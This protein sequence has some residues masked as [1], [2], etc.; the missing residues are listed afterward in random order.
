MTPIDNKKFYAQSIQRFGISPQGVHWNSKYSQ[1]KRFEIITSCIKKELSTSTI[2]D[3]GC[4]FAEYYCYLEKNNYTPQEYIGIDCEEQ[5]IEIAQERFP[6]LE[7]YLKDVLNNALIKADYYVCSGALN[8]LP[9]EQFFQF[10]RNA[11][12]ASKKGFIFNFLK[13]DSFNGIN[14]KEV[15][16]FCNTLSQNIEIQDNYLDNDMTLFLK[17][18]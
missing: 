5:M 4:G 1:Y 18:A 9:K 6:F 17:R 11:W 3:A 16:I 15:I 2:I 7:F 8:I 14:P 10:I 12:N 13:E